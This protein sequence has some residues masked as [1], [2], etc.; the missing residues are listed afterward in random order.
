MGVAMRCQEGAWWVRTFLGIA[1]MRFCPEGR[2]VWKR[3]GWSEVMREL[4]ESVRVS[5][6]DV[7]T[8]VAVL[9]EAVFCTLFSRGICVVMV[10]M[11]STALG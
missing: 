4:R 9:L 5:K 1:T 3:I 8:G 7:G 11:L 10:L 6:V 2:V